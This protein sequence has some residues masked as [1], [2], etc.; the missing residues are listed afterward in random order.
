MQSKSISERRE[1]RGEK[2]RWT[3]R[4]TVMIEDHFARV[5]LNDLSAV[6]L[7]MRYILLKKFAV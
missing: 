4:C 1:K 2:N 3:M 5:K 7:E 6:S